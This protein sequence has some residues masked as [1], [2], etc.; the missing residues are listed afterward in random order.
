MVRYTGTKIPRKKDI[1]IGNDVWIGDHVTIMG[2][3]TIGDGAIIANNSHVVKN[4]EPYSIV[5]GN[6]AR[7]IKYRFTEEQINK[8]L[9]IRWW[10]WDD[11]KIARNI[12]M[13]A[14][15]NIDEFVE[16]HYHL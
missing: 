11:Q 16:K 6:P 10:F 2:G 14:K 13:I 1:S 9:T 4:V 8:L 3:I 12:P 5:G 7:L 15:D